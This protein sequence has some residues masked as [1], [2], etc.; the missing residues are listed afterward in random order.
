MVD[1]LATRLKTD[2]E[3]IEDWLKLTRAYFVMKRF[4]EAKEALEESSGLFK[5]LPVNDSRRLSY[6]RLLKDL[7]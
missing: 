5:G 3:N 2:P 4:S 1:G 7:N 6:E